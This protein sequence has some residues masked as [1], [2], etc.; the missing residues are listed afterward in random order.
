VFGMSVSV[1]IEVMP[2]LQCWA[3][4]FIAIGDAVCILP[5]AVSQWRVR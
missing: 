4:R 3:S 2:S 5:A 1:T